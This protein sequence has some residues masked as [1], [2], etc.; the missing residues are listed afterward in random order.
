MVPA[1]VVAIEERRGFIWARFPESVTVDNYRLIE[2][3]IGARLSGK[4]DRLVLDFSRTRDVYSSG[5]GLLV[6]VHKQVTEAGG[7]V[8]LV[9]VSKKI[10]ETLEG[11][12]LERILPMY[13][14]D[15]EFEISHD[16]AWQQA[17]S[18]EALG[19]LFAASIEKGIYRLTFAGH[20]DAL[21]DLSPLS[22]FQPS[23]E[24]RRYVL[25]LDTLDSMDTYG[26]Q[27]LLEVVQRII[28]H[29]GQVITY[30]ANAM[31]QE[32]LELLSIDR[33]VKHYATEREALE[34]LR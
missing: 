22:E 20:M 31:I 30:G 12:H 21:H 1:P 29:G 5:I 32:L 2:Q 8:Y 24:T 4:S 13:A 14:T 11:V 9:N 28:N 27:L 19:F 18:S 33:M 16:E 25:N 17:V 6:R 7:G 23:A 10:R 3:K 34:S 26:S 15:V